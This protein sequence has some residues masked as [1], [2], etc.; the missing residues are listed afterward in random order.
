MLQLWVILI[1]PAPEP[2]SPS[3]PSHPRSPPI[4]L[5]QK[6]A[7]P[8]HLA[9]G[10]IS[11]SSDISSLTP[12]QSASQQHDAPSGETSH[13]G[14]ADHLIPNGHEEVTINIPPAHTISELTM[15]TGVR[16]P[17]LLSP[18]LHGSSTDHATDAEALAVSRSRSTQQKRRPLSRRITEEDKDDCEEEPAA[19]PMSYF[20]SL[21]RSRGEDDSSEEE[22]SQGPL[23]VIENNPFGRPKPFALRQEVAPEAM[24]RMH[25]RNGKQRQRERKP[26]LSF[27]GSLR[28]LF[29]TSHKDQTRAESTD[30]IGSPSKHKKEKKGWSTRT[31]VN[32]KASRSQDSSDSEPDTAPKSQQPP[33]GAKLR[34]GRSPTSAA[35]SSSGWQTDGPPSASP[36]ASVRRKK[37]SVAELKGNTGG[38]TDGEL[39]ANDSVPSNP[40]SR[41]QVEILAR[42][43][44]AKRQA[45]AITPQATPVSVSRASSL[46]TRNIVIPVPSLSSSTGKARHRRATTDLS[47]HIDS[48]NGETLNDA[49]TRRPASL[50]YGATPQRGGDPSAAEKPRSKRAVKAGTVHPLPAKGSTSVS[51]MSIVEDVSRQNR[52][53]RDATVPLLPSDRTPPPST[54]KLEVP[55]APIPGVAI[56]ATRSSKLSDDSLPARRSTSLDIPY[57]PGSIF[58]QS[59]PVISGAQGTAPRKQESMRSA[60]STCQRS[61][62][63]STS[64]TE[65]RRVSRPAVSPLRSALRNPSRTPSPSP[66]Q[67]AEIRKRGA[68]VRADEGDTP[69]G[70]TPERQE[71]A[72]RIPRPALSGQATQLNGVSVRDSVSMTSISSYATGRES[73]FEEE[74]A[75]E[76]P[77][78]SQHDTETST[79]STEMPLA[80]R[81][82]VRVSLHPTFSPTPPALEDDETQGRYPWNPSGREGNQNGPGEP[83]LWQDSSDE[84]EEYSRARKLLSRVGRKGKGKKKL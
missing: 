47:G 22:E 66:V 42:H 65:P 4:T 43:P 8:P 49:S 5:Q 39:D 7:L 53:S 44:S 75:P 35:A 68:D 52:N 83:D 61:G 79:I 33:G 17:S 50:T 34:K 70:R 54:A 57:A 6:S 24:E 63:V 9:K 14:I 72:Q 2:S 73:P 30:V 82:S 80:R 12:S 76:A 60:P 16:S 67:L 84:D 48:G 15:P 21:E 31:D 46:S 41:T 62:S 71:S 13:E 29:R 55:R 1:H 27:F 78:A 37:K 69:C 58:S 23:E 20:P 45:S 81:K 36:R 19:I 77:P 10:P 51:L 3:F 32:L 25:E 40:P 74:L 11:Y 28:G 18:P 26:S 59:L 38:Y 64:G 56:N